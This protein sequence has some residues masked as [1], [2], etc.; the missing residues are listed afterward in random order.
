M[1]GEVRENDELAAIYEKLDTV[2]ITTSISNSHR[3]E[4]LENRPRE[5]EP[6]SRYTMVPGT[7]THMYLHIAILQV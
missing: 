6:G 5:R 3:I 7:G 1:V 2:R 4:K